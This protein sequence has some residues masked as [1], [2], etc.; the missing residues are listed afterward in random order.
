MNVPKYVNIKQPP[1]TEKNLKT[2]KLC[3]FRQMTL[4]NYLSL[5]HIKI[6]LFKS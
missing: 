1:K 2:V 4:L 5:Y 6:N 3:Y